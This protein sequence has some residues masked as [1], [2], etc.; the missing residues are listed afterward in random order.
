VTAHLVATTLVLVPTA[1]CDRPRPWLPCWA[2]PG[3]PD[4]DR[5][6][7]DVLAVSVRRVA[8]AVGEG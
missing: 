5:P 6:Q 2:W 7:L 3:R 8:S 1:A 4:P